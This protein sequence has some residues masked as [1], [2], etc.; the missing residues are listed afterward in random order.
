MHEQQLMNVSGGGDLVV[1]CGEV[2]GTQGILYSV[3]HNSSNVAP[4]LPHI[5]TKM[6]PQHR[7]LHASYRR[8]RSGTSTSSCAAHHQ[9][10]GHHAS[11]T[12]APEAALCDAHKEVLHRCPHRHALQQLGTHASKPRTEI[13]RPDGCRRTSNNHVPA[14]EPVTIT[15]LL[16]ALVKHNSISVTNIFN[17][18]YG[19]ITWKN[20]LGD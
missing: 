20:T 11:T 6:F 16:P 4:T 10:R 3:P 9:P 19:I 12:R 5:P 2:Q 14:G 7:C 1:L 17:I 15:C 13:D 18:F 8:Q